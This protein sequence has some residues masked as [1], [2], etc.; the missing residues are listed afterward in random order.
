MNN[1]DIHYDD[2]I[3]F[4]KTVARHYYPS[5]R[6]AGESVCFVFPNRRSQVFFRH[7]LTTEMGE[8]EYLLSPP[9]MTF[10]EFKEALAG[11]KAS[12]SLALLLE[13]YECYK[14]LY[15]GAE[16]LDEFIYWGGVILRDFSDA[17]SSRA[18]VRLLYTNVS[19]YHKLQ[20]DLSYMTED[21]KAAVAAFVDHFKEGVY[22]ASA[23]GM[24]V[25]GNFLKIW[26]ILYPLYE[27]FREKIIPKGMAYPGMIDRMGADLL[28]GKVP[29]SESLGVEEILS[30]LS[31]RTIRECRKFVFV[32]LGLLS[33]TE[34]AILRKLHR[35]RMAEFCWDYCPAF[36]DQFPYIKEQM[37]LFG[38]CPA[39]EGERFESPLF[40]V[41]SSPSAVGQ[42]KYI[43]SI[44]ASVDPTLKEVGTLPGD[45]KEGEEGSGGK[46][47]AVVL[48]DEALLLPVLN[49]IPPQVP[50]INV[51]MGNPLSGSALFSLMS[52]IL[53][54]Q[55]HI[56]LSKDGG[57]PM[58][59][60]K[61]VRSILSS[62]IIRGANDGEGEEGPVEAIF[63]RVRQDA[64][65]FIP[66]SDLA[67]TPVTDAIFRCVVSPSD[68]A[69]PS[70][71]LVRS[72]ERYLEDVIMKVATGLCE[73]PLAFELDYAKM[74]L[75]AIHCLEQ[76]PLSLRLATF[77]RTL[78][79]ELRSRS[80]PFRGEPLC[81]LQVMGVLEMSCLDFD[82]VIILS[83]NEGTFPGKSFGASFIPGEL[84]SAF[85]LPTYWVT[86]QR[87]TYEFYCMISRA[88]NVWMMFDSRTEGLQTGEES[89][90]IKQ[91]QYH[92]RVPLERY[93][94]GG[95]V[96]GSSQEGGIG[97]TPEMIEKIRC[98][99][100]SAT[101]LKNY[102][103]CG[104]SFY[105]SVVEGLE[106]EDDVAESL[107]N[108]MIGNVFHNT[109]EALLM[110]PTA[111]EPSFS[112]ERKDIKEAIRT[113]R[114]E[115]LRFVDRDYL[116]SW[117]GS[118]L[119]KVKEKVRSLILKEL[120][121]REVSGRNLVLEKIITQYILK[122]IDTDLSLM[123]EKGV[124]RIEI[125]GLEKGGSIKFNGFDLVGYIDRLDSVERG[126]TRVIDYKTGKVEEKEM[127]VDGSN[128]QKVADAIFG[129][130][131]LTG[132]DTRPFISLQMFIYDKFVQEMDLSPEGNSV[133]NTIYNVQGM[134]SSTPRQSP[135]VRE[136]MEVMDERVAALLDEI[137]DI[138]TP[139]SRTPRLSDCSYCSFKDLCGRS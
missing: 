3:P 122:A 128:W 23:E 33:P 100:Y 13:L 88:K 9:T 118:R 38:Q 93:V 55:G 14:V 91:L 112:M 124:E 35:A 99:K 117:K 31:D 129:P 66:L 61:P 127:S 132:R 36:A 50:D 59:Y 30:S 68:C 15:K 70:E 27:A 2:M 84:R 1:R 7:Y 105:Y 90:Y 20:D 139:F 135:L 29:S 45:L 119:P 28:E 77:S 75:D 101:S 126:V 114:I 25:K 85:G 102:L 43:P 131:S 26:D 51:T 32:G 71:E 110:G 56:R 58:F 97:K 78:E 120:G 137:A 41:V 111:M 8:G 130:P 107:D 136:F 106:P 46:D 123:N 104:V 64:K 92:Y 48:A 62:P 94:L 82:N 134:F 125:L 96:L 53:S 44:L 22:T 12:S 37:D 109:M 86:D 16:P 133:V 89:R 34:S 80:V 87:R 42:A 81:G 54:L 63:Q 47:F 115:P 18:P 10:D 39:L 76:Y 24:D 74:Y 11:R 60:Y 72:M 57:E 6:E 21:Q 17:D 40:R 79:A 52:D 108:A 19:D 98:A 67:G 65:Y 113:G 103:R 73:T 83:C 5:L 95:T 138:N 4:L 121:S 116:L 49:S 69:T